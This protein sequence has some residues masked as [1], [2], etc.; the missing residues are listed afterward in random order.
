MIHTAALPYTPAGMSGTSAAASMLTQALIELEATPLRPETMRASKLL[1]EAA[2]T[3]LLPAAA[4]ISLSESTEAAA[5]S[6]V[7]VAACGRALR[8]RLQGLEGD[9]E[10]CAAEADNA[11]RGFTQ[12]HQSA[13]TPA[14]TTSMPGLPLLHA[15]SFMLRG[16][17]LFG[18]GRAE[19][20]E[21]AFRSALAAAAAAAE[22]CD[23]CVEETV[24][25]PS[26]HALGSALA[27]LVHKL[28][29]LW[30]ARSAH[31]GASACSK[32]LLRPSLIVGGSEASCPPHPPHHG[33]DYVEPSTGSDAL[34]QL[35]LTAQQQG[36]H[37]DP[38]ARCVV[39]A[40][41]VDGG[42]MMDVTLP[43]NT[44]WLVPGQLLGA[45][46]PKSR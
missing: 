46:T 13:G 17:A 6:A 44:S 31:S 27:L 12:L 37:T 35:R 30:D 28:G 36:L 4:G 18:L 22:G 15:Y 42:Q 16:K 43:R 45:S 26:D 11:L 8:A 14:P 41:A 39:P 3:L 23:R 10:G 33:C 5:S 32:L 7:V 21:E 9:L 2:T 1:V 34:S 19:E 20:A 29:G 24:G 25:V 38:R 40:V